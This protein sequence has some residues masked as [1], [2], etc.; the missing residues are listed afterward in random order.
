MNLED[1]KRDIRQT[2]FELF[3]HYHFDFKRLNNDLNGDY[4]LVIVK[5]VCNKITDVWMSTDHIGH[6]KLYFHTG[7]EDGTLVRFSTTDLSKYIMPAGH[8]SHLTL[9]PEGVISK[10]IN[11]EY[12]MSAPGKIYTEIDNILT[13]ARFAID[14][15]IEKRIEYIKSIGK[16]VVVNDSGTLYDKFLVSIVPE[17][18][19]DN[20]EYSK[21]FDSPAFMLDYGN[22]FIYPFLDKTY[23]R[24]IKRIT[25]S[26]R[27]LIK[28]L[29]IKK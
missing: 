24:L 16:E 1:K 19:V 10:E 9:N 17:V 22:D 4:C 20:N 15:I 28:R 3:D 13:I 11:T 27:D 21:E 8:M 7:G 2:L 12:D 23:M 14:C 5:E 26:Q 6:K 25:I 18:L 29:F